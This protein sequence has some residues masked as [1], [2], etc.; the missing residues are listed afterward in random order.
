MSSPGC[1]VVQK[2]RGCIL[3]KVCWSNKRHEGSWMTAA[4]E[5]AG[6]VALR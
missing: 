3:N 4:V 5:Q 1:C 2:I 6:K